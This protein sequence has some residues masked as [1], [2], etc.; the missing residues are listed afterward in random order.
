MPAWMVSGKLLIVQVIAEIADALTEGGPA[1]MLAEHQV[2]ARH[3]DVLWEKVR[4]D[5]VTVVFTTPPTVTHF[6][7]A[8]G[9][10]DM[11][12]VQSS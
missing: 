11:S 6:R 1:R 4:F 5:A 8:F 2:G 9:S 3:A 12:V 7:D 10:R